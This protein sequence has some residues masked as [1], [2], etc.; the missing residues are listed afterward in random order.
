MAQR[1]PHDQGYKRLFSH[2]ASVEELLRG[3]LREDWA[4]RL[5]V[6]TLER[7]GSSFVSDDLRE[8]HSDLIWRLRFRDGSK[9]WCYLLLELQSTSYHFMA[10]RLSSYA[11]LLQEEVIRKEKLRA[12]D[13]LP[14]VLSIV[15]Y[16]GERP[17]RAPRELRRLYGE[18]EPGL[19]RWLP[20]LHYTLLDVRRLKLGSPE[21]AGNWLA[22]L[23]RLEAC[24]DPEKLP[25]LANQLASTLPQGQPE[26]R[27]TITIWI[28]SV[29]R[30][31]FPRAII[32]LVAD[33]AEEDMLEQALIRWAKHVERKGELLGMRKLL[34]QTL[35][36]RFGRLPL[37]VRR[38][39]EEIS[40]PREL[41][42]L[43]RR[44]L[45]AETLHDTGLV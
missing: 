20:D 5:D 8:R 11:A 39:I 35:T 12:G 44:I 41:S 36:Q 19:R 45:I 16:N 34:L 27:R 13:R 14:L 42:D 25:C 28:D 10:V 4:D 37:Q 43:N 26:L 38:Q 24:K 32:P 31:A 9:S 33:L 7:I 18:A 23:L 1:V 21:L 6:S 22:M 15:F 2:A 3:F 40:T 29:F 30:R 17:W